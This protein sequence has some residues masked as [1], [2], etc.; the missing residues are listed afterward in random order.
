[1]P[2]DKEKNGEFSYTSPEVQRKTGL[3][4]LAIEFVVIT[5][6]VV[7]V[8]IFLNYTKI[9][10]FSA[11][12]DS[13][14]RPVN[15]VTNPKKPAEI[16]QANNP[17]ITGMAATGTPTE[18]PNSP[19]VEV[20]SDISGYTITLENQDKLLELLNSWGTFN[21]EYQTRYGAEG[22]TLAVP[23]KLIVV[24]LTGQKQRTNY[25]GQDINN[26]M[27]S[28]LT[29]INPGKFDIYVYIEPSI[30]EK[31]SSQT[32]PGRL[33]GSEFLTS[34]YKIVNVAQ[35]PEEAK[36]I[37]EQVNSDFKT[38]PLMRIEYFKIEKK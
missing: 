7:G 5:L 15:T 23:L 28:S 29:K 13:F 22:Q 27:S 6:I 11:F 19:T 36:K 35:T 26:P 37:A 3:K 21:K 10:P 34:L 31:N 33:L 12:L 18:L 14:K 2:N 32:P 24:H 9:L 30:I 16:Q 4:I 8:F 25:Y 17:N 38:N 20:V 1:M